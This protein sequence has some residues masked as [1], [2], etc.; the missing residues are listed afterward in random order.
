MRTPFLRSSPARRSS[1]NTPKRR[2]SAGWVLEVMV[3]FGPYLWATSLA[4]PRK[5][6]AADEV[7]SQLTETMAV[8]QQGRIKSESSCYPLS[9][10]RKHCHLQAN[11][12]L[13]VGHEAVGSL[14]C[15]NLVG[16]NGGRLGSGFPQQG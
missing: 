11:A 2:I 8:P 10:F 12:R 4:L 16:G 1:S 6:R 13:G 14:R 9:F 5:R 15:S 3:C 7:R